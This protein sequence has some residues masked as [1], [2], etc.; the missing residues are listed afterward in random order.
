MIK[1][2]H[3]RDRAVLVLLGLTAIALLLCRSPLAAIAGGV[4]LL[5]IAVL[6][7]RLVV[8]DYFG[9]RGAAGPWSTILMTWIALVAAT[10]LTPSIYQLLR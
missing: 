3:H 10:A 7:A 4:V 9:F 2:F 1:R 6:K 8:L 5:V